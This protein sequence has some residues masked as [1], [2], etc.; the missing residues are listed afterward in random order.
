LDGVSAGNELAV[1]TNSQSPVAEA[2]RVLR[3]NLQFAAVG[4]ELRTLLVTSPAPNEGKSMTIG[5]LGAALAQAGQK[6][7]VVDSDLHRPRLHKVF[8]LRNNLGVTTALLQEHPN[9]DGLLQDTSI[10]GLRVLTSGPLPPNPAELLGS[11]RMRELRDVLTARADIVL[12]DSPPATALSDTA[13]LSTQMDGV[14]LVVDAG[15]TRREMARRAVE[16]LL[17][18]NAHIVGVLLN[19][20]P[21]Q[22]DSAYYYYYHYDDYYRVDDGQSSGGKGGAGRNG[23]GLR[24]RGSVEAPQAIGEARQCSAWVSSGSDA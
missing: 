18:V 6:V 12:F 11:A 10:S 24:R 16:A 2:Y 14:L 8:G 20:M 3:T 15:A 19:R 7:I 9:V 1:L 22:S 21:T 13:I 5:N 23:R 17:R 4:H